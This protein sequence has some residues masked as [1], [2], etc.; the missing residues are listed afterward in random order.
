[1]I[2]W[3]Y[4]T[5]RSHTATITMWVSSI[6][7]DC[8]T[9]AVTSIAK[10]KEHDASPKSANMKTQPSTPTSKFVSWVTEYKQYKQTFQSYV[11]PQITLIS[12]TYC[13][14][15]SWTAS[16]RRSRAHFRRFVITRRRGF[17][18]APYALVTSDFS[19]SNSLATK[20]VVAK[21]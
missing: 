7:P 3:P 21:T 13:A 17:L 16:P 12:R 8:L 4:Y 9:R 11:L 1:M 15:F 6:S 14:F 20:S 19:C 5:R 10:N 2:Q 18:D